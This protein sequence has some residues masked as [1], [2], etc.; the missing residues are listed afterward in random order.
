MARGT[1]ILAEYGFGGHGYGTQ[2]ISL[3]G[4]NR[5]QGSRLIQ[6]GDRYASILNKKIDG[7]MY[8]FLAIIEDKGD[9]DIAF[10]LLEKILKFFEDERENN[11]SKITSEITL[12]M[13]RQIRVLMVSLFV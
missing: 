3:I 1:T 13:S 6:L 10:D 9:R 4:K 11:S 12:H 7:D 8:S 2:A 5:S